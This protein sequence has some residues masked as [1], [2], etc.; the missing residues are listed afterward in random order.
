MLTILQTD[1]NG[2]GK[3]SNIY[4]DVMSGSN[5]RSESQVE[6]DRRV[7]SYAEFSNQHPSLFVIHP[8]TGEPQVNCRDLRVTG[9]VW[10]HLAPDTNK[11]EH[12]IDSGF[13]DFLEYTN[14]FSVRGI[15]VRQ[16]YILADTP[17]K[18]N[19]NKSVFGYKDPVTPAPLPDKSDVEERARL[20]Y[21]EQYG[22]PASEFA[23]GLQNGFMDGYVQG[24]TDQEKLMQGDWVKVSE[25]QKILDGYVW[26]GK[27]SASDLSKIIN[28]LYNHE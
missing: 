28:K 24:A 22:E 9:P 27:L 16:V 14:Y 17:E 18:P 15:E 7:V 1:E 21:L 6:Y 11:W 23:D 13:K 8:I 20:L 26:D 10:Q 4:S 19:L 12:A 2:F 3:P 25:V 5:Y